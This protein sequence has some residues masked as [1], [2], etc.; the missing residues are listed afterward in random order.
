M[1]R[2]NI[3][4]YPRTELPLSA[5][6]TFLTWRQFWL[7]NVI[8]L[9]ILIFLQFFDLIHLYYLKSH[10]ESREEQ[11]AQLQQKFFQL[12]SSFP[13][14]FFTQEANQSIKQL[15]QDVATQKNILSTIKNQTLFS[16]DLLALSR[17]IVKNVWLTQINVVQSGGEITLKGKSL[18]KV[19][20]ESFLSNLQTEKTFTEYDFNIKNIEN[21]T[22]KN[23]SILIF[24]I[25]LAKKTS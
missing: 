18:D 16:E 21:M 4:L 10:K 23:T 12:K 19:S 3:N 24:E 11:V 9:F 7:S 13:T 20:L 1:L 15:E 14:L 17:S 6:V 5:T 25:T 8:I 22:E 2:Q